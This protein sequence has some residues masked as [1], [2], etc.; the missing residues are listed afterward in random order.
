MQDLDLGGLM[1]FSD[2][3]S[4]WNNRSNVKYRTWIWGD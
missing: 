1:D 3:N 2:W 4:N